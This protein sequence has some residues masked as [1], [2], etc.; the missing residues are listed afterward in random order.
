MFEKTKRGR[1]AKDISKVYVNDLLVEFL[2]AKDNDWGDRICYFKIVDAAC[3]AKT[4]SISCLLEDGIRMP[5]WKTDKNEIILK[6][7]EKFVNKTNELHKGNEYNADAVFENYCIE[8]EGKEPIK[9]Y[10]LKLPRLSSS[11]VNFY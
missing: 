5:Y 4:K 2:S 10:Y 3:K 1:P 7:K 8:N 6:V 11:N 9:G